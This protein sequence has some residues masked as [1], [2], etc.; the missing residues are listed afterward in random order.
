V[1][2]K[3]GTTVEAVAK[4]DIAKNAEESYGGTSY[5]KITSH[6][7][8]ASKAV[9]VAGQKGYAGPLEGGHEQGRRRLRRVARFPSPANAKQLV[10]VRFGVDVRPEAVR[11]RRDHQG[12]QGA[13]S[14]G[15][16]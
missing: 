7:V 9:T 1:L 5:G 6:E 12:H 10:V 16:V 2:G 4:A 8:L 15:G 13:A 3:A 14:G 11:H